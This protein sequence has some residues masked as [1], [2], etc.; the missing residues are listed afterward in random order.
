MDDGC[1]LPIQGSGGRKPQGKRVGKDCENIVSAN[2]ILMLDI[3]MEFGNGNAVE[4]GG[5][6]QV[7]MLRSVAV[8]KEIEGCFVGGDGIIIPPAS[9]IRVTD[10]VKYSV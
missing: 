8:C 2:S 7:M 5:D 4:S 1:R 10:V 9:P 6:V 3:G